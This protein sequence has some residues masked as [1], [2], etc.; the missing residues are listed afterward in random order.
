MEFA[1]VLAREC[2]LEP[3]V[4]ADTAATLA[5]LAT[6]HCR[7]QE[8]KCNFPW[9]D[10]Q[11]SQED[12]LRERITTLA[13]SIGCTGLVFSGDPRGATVKL[14]VPSGYT[15]DWGNEGVCVPE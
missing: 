9:T 15:N 5:R 14:V 8:A 12:A 10:K 11:Q 2:G 1:A 4:A 6:K 13:K 7:L 3:N